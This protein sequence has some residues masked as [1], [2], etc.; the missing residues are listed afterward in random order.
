M[1]VVFDTEEYNFQIEKAKELQEEVYSNK[2]H[3]INFNISKMPK[4]KKK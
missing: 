4:N 2:K 3:H 1:I